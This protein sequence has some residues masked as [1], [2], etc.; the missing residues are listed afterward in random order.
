MG[1]AG[2][3]SIS[4]AKGKLICMIQGIIFDFDGTLFDSMFIWDTAGETY[5]ASIGKKPSED[6][7]RVL[8]PMSLYQSAAYMRETYQIDL[9]VKEIMEGI[10]RT[11]ESFYFHLV[12]P[13]PGV[14]EFLEALSLKGMRMCIA[15]ATDRYQVEAALKRCSIDKYF[16]RI[17][18]CTEVGSGKDQPAIFRKAMEYLGTERSNT[19][20]VEDAWHAVYTAKKDGFFVAAVYDAHE[21]MQSCIRE[22]ADIY[23]MDY[24]D[25][26]HF[27]K[28]ASDE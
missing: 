1:A 20:V 17:F 24:F 18:T 22:L 4:Y 13:K 8:K 23:L 26:D 16:S 7:Q 14:C 3:T 10:N 6:L 15:T 2:I 19:L 12:E 5:L 9:S 28:F 11:V 27:W 21:N 25:V